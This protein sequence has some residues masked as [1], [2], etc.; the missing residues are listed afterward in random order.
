M[1][2]RSEVPFAA[3]VAVGALAI[4][5]L[6]A[7]SETSRA[8]SGSRAYTLSADFADGLLR[9]V[10][11][12]A[13]GVD[14]LQLNQIAAPF[15]FV[16]IAAS[17]RGAV[18]RI[19]A[20]SG[21][22]LGEYAT[23]PDGMGKNPSRTAVDRLGNVWVA[24][25]NEFG[26]SPAGSGDL[27]GSAV[28]VGLTIGGERSTADGTVDPAGQYLKPP[29]QYSTCLDRD[30]DGLIK[31][32]RGL[33]DI[34]AW[35]NA[36]GVDSHGGVATAEDECIITYTRVAGTGART[37]AVDANNDV[38]VGGLGDRDHERLDGETG[39]PIAGTAFNLGCGGYGGLID[40]SGVLWSSNPPLRYDPATA[41]GAC[42]PIGNYGLGLDPASGHVWMSQCGDGLCELD[43]A[44]NVVNSYASPVAGQGLAVAGNGHVWVAELFG[45]Q[46]AH[47]APDPADPGAHFLVGVVAGFE[48]ATGVAVDAN[49]KVWV[50]EITSSDTRGAARI[51]PDGGAAGGGGYRVG[52]IDLTVGLDSPELPPAEP[53]NYSNMAGLVAAGTAPRG[54]WTVVF[55]SEQA[56]AEWGAVSWNTENASPCPAS[57]TARV[58]AGASIAARVRSAETQAG[59]AAAAA[60]D[61]PNGADV[62]PPDGRFLQV[63][64]TLSASE[65]GLSP[66]LC[67]LTVRTAAGAGPPTPPPT[68]TSTPTATP[69]NTPTPTATPTNT[70]TPT[71]MPT[72]TPTSTSTPTATPTPTATATDTPTP[73]PTL[74]KTLTPT[75]TPTPTATKTPRPTAT[76]T[77]TPTAT[78]TMTP[79][80]TTTD[81]PT[82]TPTKTPRPTATPSP[83]PTATATISPSA[84]ALAVDCDAAAAGAQAACAVTL[85][86]SFSVQ[87]HAKDPGD[88]YLAFQVKP[89]WSDAQLDY[90]PAASPAGENR[91]PP[92]CVAARKIEQDGDQLGRD[93]LLFG[94]ASDPPAP[95][96][97]TGPVAAFVMRCD[98]DG[99][100]TIDLVPKAGDPQLGT[101]LLDG[102]G[103]R[104][105]PALGG[106]QV[107]C[108]DPDTDDDGCTDVEEQSANE[109]NGGGREPA[110]FWDFFDTPNA[111]QQPGPPDY[112]R[113]RAVAVDDIF[114]V[115]ARFGSTDAGPGAFD[116][117]SDP[118]SAPAPPVSPP[119]GRA[120][121]HPAFDRTTT[122]GGDAWDAGPPD[123]AIATVDIANIVAQ[124]G[125]TCIAPPN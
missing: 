43:A 95:S 115:V 124:F 88:G 14:Q 71:A 68:S 35:S 49:G 47:F 51:D 97:H 18:V 2:P 86:V 6:V 40:A 55:D 116:R 92:P 121:Y 69:T 25:R 50:S 93:A 72:N 100:A 73:S 44:G 80:A 36:G 57:P 107:T 113:D 79:T 106:A 23:A 30:G 37:L 26:E 22:V 91:W 27:K 123:G 81:T 90:L 110:S 13:P 109:L 84:G 15:P 46:V 60:I 83:T 31:T 104:V 19:D 12:D 64:V 8:V 117:D 66:L 7:G 70:P 105:H 28:R 52:A 67:D 111:N 87:V 101:F 39:L 62:D 42:L 59:L 75:A 34:L 38:W 125:H 45:D 33:G 48:G 32:S 78:N 58:P 112:Q 119:G 114:R 21:A 94:C 11:H 82:P 1:P 85:G 5:V 77:P 89:E 108:V 65:G 98:A 41:T 29:F 3:L 99:P 53:Y 9:N 54:A 120:N 118:L 102:A 63:E 56:G 10:N 16:N 103:N 76:A 20:V 17:S 74:T 122:P 4:A 24:N 61:A 96:A